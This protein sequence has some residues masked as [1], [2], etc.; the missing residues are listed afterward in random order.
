MRQLKHILGMMQPHLHSQS[1]RLPKAELDYLRLIYTVSQ[2]RKLGESVQGYFI[3]TDNGMLRRLKK[4]EQEYHSKEYADL[5]SVSITGYL[6]YPE[7]K[8][9]TEALSE[10]VKAAITGENG[11][12]SASS[13]RRS[14]RDFIL[15][16]TILG[17]EPDAQ[18][19]TDEGKFPF[20]VRWDYYGLT[21]DKD[22]D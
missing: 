13:I 2:I 3:V 19:V 21:G 15:A 16:D 20:E 10:I 5:I 14:I 18:R 1:T 8:G 7:G 22:R 17:L 11:S 12:Q 9:K 4:L 6:K